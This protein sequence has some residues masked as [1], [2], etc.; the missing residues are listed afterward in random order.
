MPARAPLALGALVVLGMLHG[1]LWAVVVP[2]WQ[3]PDEPKHLEYV[4]LLAARGD[5]LAFATEDEAADPALQ[6]A[7]LASM[8]RHRFWWFG[9]APGYVQGATA[10]DGEAQGARSDEG[11]TPGA[12]AADGE[13]PGAAAPPTRFRDV[14]PLGTHTAYY[15][16]SPAWYWLAARLQPAGLEAGLYAA[17]LLSVLLGAGIVLA[18]GVAARALFPDDPLARYGAPALVALHPMVAAVHATASP[19]ALVGLLV[20]LAW[21][22]ACR[23]LARGATTARLALLA[24][25][26][27]AAVL[28]KRTALAVAPAIV[29]GALW[30]PLASR[31]GLATSAAVLAALLA[32][33]WLTWGR[34]A[35]AT[36]WTVLRYLFNEPDQPSRILGVLGAPAA[37]PHLAG[38]LRR[39]HDGYWGVFGWET[40]RYPG[41][42][43]GVLL[44][45]GIVAGVGVLFRVVRRDFDRAQL[46]G[47]TAAAAAVVGVALAATAFFAS[48]LATSYAQPPQGRYL[49]V[50]APMVALWLAVGLGAWV[51]VGARGRAAA[52]L[53]GLLAVTD[54]VVLFGLVAPYFRV[55]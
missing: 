49:V 36:R 26:L 19:D 5:A 41:A 44:G 2:P 33:A 47:L 31:R 34:L 42:V 50:A 16:A 6:E 7:I 23:A 9:R 43:Y 24:A 21:L 12:N 54:A 4:R 55:G 29:L 25:L 32:G 53:V 48:Y 38:Y 35:E 8:D 37:W 17:R 39:I 18:T 45:V 52:V 40:V 28:V 22:L 1:L 14:W 46:G 27:A 51:P 11:E 30:R 20:A 13:A 3:N 15:R 10:A